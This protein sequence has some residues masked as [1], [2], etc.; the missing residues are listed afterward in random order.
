MDSQLLPT[1]MQ[2]LGLKPAFASELLAE[3][4]EARPWRV[5]TVERG[6][7]AVVGVDDDGAVVE[8]R[9]RSEGRA[10][11]VG[12]W[13]VL[14]EIPDMP[15]V[16]AVLER[17]TR[18]VRGAVHRE[19]QEQLIAANLDTVFVVAA[20]AETQKLER[21]SIRARRLD[22][23]IAAVKD[24]GSVPV[25]VLNKV[26][27]A[28]RDPEELEVLR[29]DLETRLGGVMVTC[30]SAEG[31]D[32][33]ERLHEWLG[34]GETVAF[35]GASGVGK[36][37]LINALLGERRLDVGE[38]RATDTKGRHTTT[39]RELVML[40]SGALLVDTPGVREFAL[41][42][43][44]AAAGFEDVQALA[45]DCRFAD[46]AHETEPGCAVLEAV[47]RGEVARDRIESYRDLE[48]EARR[49]RGKHDSYARHLEHLE[50]RKFGRL[51]REATSIKKNR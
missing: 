35:V 25:V 7:C 42:A 18:L 27:L 39:R 4:G 10:I 1:Y 45:R 3:H 23:F 31:G 2:K 49:Q 19:G 36:S 32:G 33:L 28:D 47:E 24:G 43:D 14:D 30:V 38:V 34:L 5:V 44:D 8:Q 11:A 41:A 48:N 20:F 51:V 16:A 46:C 29:K 13:V 9:A 21:R 26:D 37:S 22:R 17:V 40:P 50:R 15:R 12:D 6:L